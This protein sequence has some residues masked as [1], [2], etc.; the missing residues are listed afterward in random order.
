MPVLA[1]EA[2]DGTLVAA[3][4]GPVSGHAANLLVSLAIPPVA[5]AAAPVAVVLG[6]IAYA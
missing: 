1:R 4:S 3:V 2:S 6:V 5:F